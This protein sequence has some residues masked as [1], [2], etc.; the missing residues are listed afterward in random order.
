MHRHVRLQV[1]TFDD[2]DIRTVMEL[3][4]TTMLVMG[5]KTQEFQRKWSQWEG[6]PFSTMVNS[7]SSANLLIVQLLIS[8]RGRYQLQPGDEVLIPAVTWSTTLFPVL[9]LGLKPVLV[10]VKPDTM[11]IDAASCRKALSRKTRAVIAVHLL[12]NP[13]NM[14]ELADLCADHDLVL[15]EDCC[16][17]HGALWHR[18]KVGSF[19]A[20]SSFSFMFAHHMSTIEGG[21]VCCSTREDDAILKATR[22]HGWI[23]EIDDATR[24]EILEKTPHDDTRFL[25]WDVGFNVRPTEIS[26]ALGSSQLEK[27]DRYI[28]TRNRNH[29]LYRRELAPVSEH[30]QVQ[31]PEDPV[32]AGPSSFA[33]GLYIRDTGRF[34]RRD[35]VAHLEA[36]GVESRPL[37]AGNLAR[38]PFYP[39]YCEPPRVE[40]AVSDAIHVGGL[41]LPNHQGMSEDD[42]RYVA[43]H[44]REFFLDRS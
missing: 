27:L 44:V 23:R 29:E 12:G 8:K 16:E 11:N 14:D 31:E 35:L 9:Q 36:R 24:K 42:V 1:S 5:E 39:L 6:M 19:G 20:L 41:Y 26:A 33:F 37:V 7:G 17:A 13:A 43:S 38:H 3:F 34:R 21:V 40:L 25:F 15:V 4:D 18:Q 30:I 22:A 32:R 28:D 2:S 10:D